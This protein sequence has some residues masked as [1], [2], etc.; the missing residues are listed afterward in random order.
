MDSGIATDLFFR[1]CRNAGHEWRLYNDDYNQY[2][3]DPSGPEYG[4]WISQVAS[5]HGI[6]QLDLHSIDHFASDLKEKTAEGLP[7]YTYTYTFIEPNFG[8][9]FFSPQPPHKG[10]RT[11][12]QRRLVTTS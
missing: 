12:V 1:L 8:R 10:Q 9:S 11:H 3:D 6:S 4:G 7:A 2:S 5:L